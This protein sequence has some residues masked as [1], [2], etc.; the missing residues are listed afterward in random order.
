MGVNVALHVTLNRSVVKSAGPVPMK[1]GRSNTF[2][3]TKTFGADGDDVFVWR[4]VG[5][6]L[7]HLRGRFVLCVIVQ[8]YVAQFLFDIPS[9]LGWRDVECQLRRC[10]LCA[11]NNASANRKRSARQ[12]RCF[13]L[14]AHRSSPGQFPQSI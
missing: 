7:V 5:L 14:G 4:L 3:A 1:P 6:L 12:S 10:A 9:N 8:T 13:R 2:R 11:T